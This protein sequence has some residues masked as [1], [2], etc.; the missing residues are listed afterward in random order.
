ML[1]HCSIL[2]LITR[3]VWWGGGG[4]EGR[5][6]AFVKRARPTITLPPGELICMLISHSFPEFGHFCRWRMRAMTP[7]CKRVCVRGLWRVTI[8]FI[9][10]PITA[11]GDIKVIC[12]PLIIS[13]TTNKRVMIAHMSAVY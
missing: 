12:R 13:S 4:V 8:N 11:L 5:G 10:G 6:R 3:G 7:F 9:Y 1:V 2:V